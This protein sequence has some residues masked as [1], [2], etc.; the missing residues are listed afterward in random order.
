MHETAIPSVYTYFF[1][2][3]NELFADA[4][5][6]KALSVALD[7]N[8]IA[9]LTGRSVK[10]AAGLVP[11]GAE[12]TVQKTDFRKGHDLIAPTGDAEAAKALLK[13]AGVRTGNIAIDYNKER[14]YEEAV[15][16]Y[17][18]GVWKELGFKVKTNIGCSEYKIDIGIVCPDNEDEYLM[19][20]SCMGDATLEKT[21]ARDRNILQPSVLK[22]LGWRMYSVNILDWYDNSEQVIEKLALEE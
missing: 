3:T 17:V 8:E 4:R 14:P 16:S 2:T 11:Y 20:I 7:R 1:D 19:G 22:G 10:P 21:T 13:E 12:E 5:V 18:A 6:R 9:R 15:A